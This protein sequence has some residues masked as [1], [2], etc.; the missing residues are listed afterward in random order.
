MVCD[1]FIGRRPAAFRLPHLGVAILATI[2]LAQPRDVEGLFDGLSA[3]GAT[4]RHLFNPVLVLR[5]LIPDGGVRCIG[6]QAGNAARKLSPTTVPAA[7][8]R[9]NGTALVDAGRY[10]GR[11]LLS[12]ISFAPSEAACQRL[13]DVPRIVIRQELFFLALGHWRRRQRRAALRP[14]NNGL[15]QI[16]FRGP[17]LERLWYW[18]LVVFVHRMLLEE[19]A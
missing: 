11:R 19:G 5:G 10:R 12:Q 16:I 13:D 17:L 7:C 14:A 1:T 8:V 4:S 9:A 2:E 3:G 18:N 15:R 6:T